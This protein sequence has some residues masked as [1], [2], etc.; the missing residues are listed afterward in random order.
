MTEKMNYKNKND[1][2]QSILNI[3]RQKKRKKEMKNQK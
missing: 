2:I 3:R 1:L